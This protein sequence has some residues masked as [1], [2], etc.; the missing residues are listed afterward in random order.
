MPGPNAWTR[1]GP[2]SLTAAGAVGA[3]PASFIDSLSTHLDQTALLLKISLPGVQTP[4]VET[5]GVAK[6]PT[7]PLPVAPDLGA[8]AAEYLAHSALTGALGSPTPSADAQAAAVLAKALTDPEAREAVVSLLRSEHGGRGS[9]LAA[10]LEEASRTAASNPYLRQLASDLSA[11]G[12]NAGTLSALFDGTT[13]K[14]AALA[15]AEVVFWGGDADS[16]P[17]R[18]AD[19]PAVTVLGASPEVVWDIVHSEND[20]ISAFSLPHYKNTYQLV[21]AT[22]KDLDVTPIGRVGRAAMGLTQ[23]LGLVKK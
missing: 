20:N 7:L 8:G 23:A 22:L 16:S 18:Q 9:E 6:D 13:A 21:L 4:S 3:I 15:V 11:A 2:F 5:H 14:A 12:P 1:L 10:K 17:F 19:I